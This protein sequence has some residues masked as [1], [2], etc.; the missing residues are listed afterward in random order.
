VI[1]GCAFVGDRER[2]GRLYD[3]LLPYRE[4][5]VLTGLPAL[6]SGS[7]ELSLALAAG[8]TNRWDVADEHFARA[9]ERNDRSGNR[10]WLVHGQYE[11]AA[12]LARREDPRGAERLGELLRGCL[13]G[14]MEM[15]MTRVVEQTRALAATAGITLE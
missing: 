14:A 15:G 13:T 3:M 9:M 12:L 10:A 1:I 2:A 7:V 11:F 8:T 5:F 4:H 6:S